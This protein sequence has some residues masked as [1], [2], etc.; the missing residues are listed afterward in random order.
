MASNSVPR[1][2]KRCNVVLHLVQVGF[3]YTVSF[4]FIFVPATEI[5]HWQEHLWCETPFHDDL[6][7]VHAGKFKSLLHESIHRKVQIERS[8]INSIWLGGFAEF[9]TDKLHLASRANNM[10]IL[11]AS[12]TYCDVFVSA[13]PLRLGGKRAHSYYDAE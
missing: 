1:S 12:P 6:V 2:F 10:C 8:I 7:C 9:H 11:S 13:D 3:W 5:M 4:F